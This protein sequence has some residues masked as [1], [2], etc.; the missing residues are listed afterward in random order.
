VEEALELCADCLIEC[1]EKGKIVVSENSP[2]VSA[3]GAAFEVHFPPTPSPSKKTGKKKSKSKRRASMP[4][5]MPTKAPVFVGSQSVDG[6]ASAVS[7][8]GA[9]VVAIAAAA[10]KMTTSASTG[11][12]APLPPHSRKLSFTDIASSHGRC[13]SFT[14][15]ASSHGRW[16]RA[17]S[18]SDIAA[19]P[20]GASG[21]Q[22][23]HEFGAHLEST[24]EGA[25]EKSPE[26]QS[27][28]KRPEVGKEGP[29]KKPDKNPGQATGEEGQGEDMV[30]EGGERRR[31]ESDWEEWDHKML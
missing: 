11:A 13:D 17:T 29:N 19:R 2:G 20:K 26:K 23:T 9:D 24:E 28:D 12:D 15:I 1:K 27:P 25:T 10:A 14:D 18:F 30:A 31:E 3:A 22:G 4:D 16:D 21:E 8:D 5:G 6:A 7:A